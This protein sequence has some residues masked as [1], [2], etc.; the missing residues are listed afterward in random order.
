MPHTPFSDPPTDRRHRRPLSTVPGSALP[1]L[2]D[3]PSHGRRADPLHA[4]G[5]DRPMAR[6][7]HLEA[8]GLWVVRLDGELAEIGGRSYWETLDELEA[9]ARGAGLALSDLIVRTGRMG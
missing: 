1:G 4:A 6:V 7:V 5:H 8:T 2:I 3:V 9:A